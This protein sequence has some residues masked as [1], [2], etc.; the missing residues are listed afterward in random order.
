MTTDSVS[1]RH[2]DDALEA[3]VGQ[4]LSA[5][6]ST[7][8]LVVQLRRR[9]VDRHVQVLASRRSG[10]ASAA[11]WRRASSS[12]HSPMLHDQAALLGERD[13]LDRRR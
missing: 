12:T 11:S 1:S 7:Q 6:C 13:E 3:V 2:S 10:G 9:E 5:T 8:V 4:R